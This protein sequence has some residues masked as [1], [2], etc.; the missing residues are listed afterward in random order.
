MSF[1]RVPAPVDL[2]FLLGVEQ[3]LRAFFNRD[4][5]VQACELRR[6][7]REPV[8]VPVFAPVVSHKA[9]F[10]RPQAF[11]IMYVVNE[12]SCHGA[13]N[14]R[15]AQNTMTNNHST[16]FSCTTHSKLTSEHFKA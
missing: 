7:Q 14:V 9:S 13:I 12:S 4:P 11:D 2:I 1:P 6:R 3:F 8:A 16:V 15:A 10:P 5:A